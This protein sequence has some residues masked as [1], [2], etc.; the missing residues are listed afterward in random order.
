MMREFTAKPS[1]HSRKPRFDSCCHRTNPEPRHPL[2][3]N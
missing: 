1:R 3:R 2:P